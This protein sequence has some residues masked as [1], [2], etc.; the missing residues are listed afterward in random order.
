MIGLTTLP[1]GVWTR[2]CVVDRERQDREAEVPVGV[3]DDRVA[4]VR[5][6][7]REGERVL[8]ELDL[9]VRVAVAGQ[10][11]DDRGRAAEE[12]RVGRRGDL[13][14]ERLRVGPEVPRAAAVDAA[15][16]ARDE[17][18]VVPRVRRETLD[19]RLDL[20]SV[21]GAAGR[22][23]RR[24]RAEALRRPVL[25]VV[26]R[27]LV[28]R[29]D[30]ADERGVAR[31]DRRRRRGGGD[32]CRGRGRGDQCEC[33]ESAA[34]RDLQA[35]HEAPLHCDV[36]RRSQHGRRGESSGQST[37]VTVCCMRRLQKSCPGDARVLPVEDVALPLPDGRAGGVEGP[38]QAPLG[39]DVVGLAEIGTWG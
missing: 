23:V 1:F 25:E 17:A 6:A 9:L 2:N 15:A 5:E 26:G 39:E 16:V 18:E 12:D 29:V 14:A 30:V 27:R 10:R 4:D 38:L 34:Q 24:A 33:Q 31:V 22:A 21:A 35:L 20:P 32:R 3:G 28:V 13:E 7:G 19:L 36:P 37:S 8:L 11:P